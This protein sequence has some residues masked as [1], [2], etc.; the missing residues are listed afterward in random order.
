[1]TGFAAEGR[2]KYF[3]ATVELLT[4]MPRIRGHA[5]LGAG[6]SRERT[7][8]KRDAADLAGVEY[9]AMERKA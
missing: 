4:V 1:M 9:A 8:R 2:E 5:D 6:D 3:R 7:T